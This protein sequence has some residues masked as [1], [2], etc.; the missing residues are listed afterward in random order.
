MAEEKTPEEETAEAAPQPKGL[1][2]RLRAIPAWIKS[3]P[4]Q[5]GLLVTA[6]FLSVGGLGYLW[7]ILRSHEPETLVTLEAALELLTAGEFK[8]AAKMAHALE[9]SN[10]LTAEEAGGPAYVLGVLAAWDAEKAIGAER[11]KFALV[12][13]RHLEEARKRDYA[14]ANKP[15]VVL[16]LG[17]SLYAAGQWNACRPVLQEALPVNPERASEIHRLLSYA[18]L[19]D[20]VP[21]YAEAY[22]ENVL[23]LTDRM[24]S[25]GDRYRG[26]LQRAEIL[27]HL[28]KLPECLESLDQ[29]PGDAREF[30]ESAVLR[31]QVLLQEARIL[32]AKNDPNL[33]ADART[34]I[35]MATHMLRKVRDQASFQR[36]AAMQASYLLGVC[37][38]DLADVEGIPRDS[39]RAMDQFEYTRST[40]PGTAEA[41]ASDWQQAEL[42]RQRKRDRESLLSYARVLKAV[43]D[44]D[45]YENAWL[46]L[47][48]L[49]RRIM[50]GYQHFLDMHEYESCVQIAVLLYPTFSRERMVQAQAE[51]YR[52][53][54]QDLLAQAEQLPIAKAAAK[55]QEGESRLREAGH[56]FEQLARMTV[57]QRRYPD[58]L[59]DAAANYFAGHNYQDAARMLQLY[60]DNEPRKRRALALANLGEC[61][62]VMERTDRALVWFSRCIDMYPRDAASFRAR[63][64]A[65]KAYAERNEIARAKD[66]LEA[67]LSG[68]ALSPASREWRE[69]LFALGRLL[70]DSKRYA[71][72]VRRL[73]EAIERYKDTR[74]A[75]E[76]RYYLA[77]TYREYALAEEAKLPGDLVEETRKTRVKH[78]RE[79]FLASL[80][81]YRLTQEAILRFQEANEL[82]TVEK[83]ILRN[84]YFGQGFTQMN[85]G[86]YEGA[87]KCYLTATNRYQNCPEIMDAYLQIA[88][89]Y[90]LMNRPNEARGTLEQAKVLLGRMKPKTPF[91]ETTNYT[92]KEWAELLGRLTSS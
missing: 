55:V 5:G 88:R 7:F 69:S 48:Q 24:L 10:R 38:L 41:L 17:K 51:T 50:E 12:A 75:I 85:L 59:W 13:A 82:S 74:Q 58:D 35:L 53:W 21:K 1:V 20:P 43:T 23:Y 83:M 30:A 70:H 2:G 22:R 79:L 11:K 45:G 6:A 8:Q 76:G 32:N 36:I 54:G 18:Y 47:E 39:Y 89:A 68:E 19:N 86:Q 46:P 63:L 37:L 84:T 62:M 77:D 73:T 90:Q 42:W 64:L 27:L 92:E 49:R 61:L 81:Q 28:Q 67:N 29:I 56:Y 72:A 91:R 66:L 57:V 52:A 34:K 15:E 25:A 14:A 44:P 78:V 16:L 3:H 26:L 33:K 65:S 80:E 60:V 9:K 40:F 87:V 31:S 4:L 71:D